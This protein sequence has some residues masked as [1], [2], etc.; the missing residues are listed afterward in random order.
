[1]AAIPDIVPREQL[2]RAN[3]THLFTGR[4]ANILGQV[5]GPVLFRLVGG[6]VLFFFNG[7]SFLISAITELFINIPQTLPQ[8]KLSP[9]AFLSKLIKD[10]GEGFRYVY[11]NKGMRGVFLGIAVVNLFMGPTTV[12]LPFYVENSLHHKMDWY[13]YIMAAMSAGFLAGSMIAASN[14]AKKQTWLVFASLPAFAL[15]YCG[16]GFPGHIALSVVLFFLL[17]LIVSIFNIHI[18][19][20]IQ[21][22][23]DS[24]KRGRVFGLLSTL[25]RSLYPI[26][27]GLSGLVADLMDQD[28]PKIFLGSGI[29]VL[30]ISLTLVASR[31]YRTFVHEARS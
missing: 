5:V 4:F 17:G 3:A 25:S 21:L 7:L 20:A 2:A 11:Q 13:G 14:W 6:P 26:S 15:C 22:S 27:L 24:S 18:T 30:L 12:L 8:E 10:T 9:R 23:T 16:L 19:T 31:P 28:I 1:M 29:C